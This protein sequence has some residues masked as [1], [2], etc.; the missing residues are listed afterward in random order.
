M[1]QEQNNENQFPRP[2]SWNGSDR[3][4]AAFRALP[5]WT[6]LIGLSVA[7]LVSAATVVSNGVVAQDAADTPMANVQTLERHIADGKLELASDLARELDDAPETES[8]LSLTLARL[9]RALQQTDETESAAEFYRRAFQATQKPA[10]AKLPPKQITLIRLA[11]ASTLLQ[12]GEIDTA[13]ES[14]ASAFATPDEASKSQKRIAVEIALRIGS[15]AFATGDHATA[16]TAYSFA[17]EHATQTNRPTAVLGAA[18]AQ[19]LEG[20]EPLLAAQKLAEFVKLFPQHS[21]AP[22]AARA[23]AACLKNANRQDDANVMLADLLRRWPSSQAAIEVV[24]NQTKTHSDV[25]GVSPAILEWLMTPTA[26]QHLDSFE[27]NVLQIGLFTAAK[28]KDARHWNGFANRIAITDTTGQV[29]S[30]VLQRLSADDLKAEAEQYAALV[31]SPNK[32]LA[33][34]ASAREAACRWAGR[35]QR[36][37]MLALA[38]ESESPE[39]ENPT[40]TLSVERLFAEALM[41]T[42]RSEDAYPWWKHL[43]DNRGADDFATLLRCAETETAF[44]DDATIAAE[45]IAAARVAAG[46]NAFQ[47]T[48]VNLLDAEVAVRRTQF[49][50]ARSLLERV[51]RASGGGNGLRGRAQ[52]LIGETY[53]LQQDFPKAIEAYRRVEGIDQSGLFVAPSLLQAGKSF[54]QLGRTREAAV[55][56]WGLVSRFAASPH[57]GMARQRLAAIDPNKNQSDQKSPNRPSGQTLRR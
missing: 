5:G 40:R 6:H 19:A 18:W 4:C 2:S 29:S 45:R 30:D 12:A 13:A 49:T 37:S 15:A 41:Q 25:N 57:A 38:S 34:T 24:A 26:L 32:N 47:I 51:V 48:L 55:C 14:V 9:A 33:V 3:S 35:T 27:S 7:L 23:C 31:V 39:Q 46:E 42:G 21:D 56:Y 17:A 36:W 28:Q 50:E 10:A 52:W 53:Y 8:D 54:E 16:I 20:K 1:V 44:G 11:A 22:R 43:V